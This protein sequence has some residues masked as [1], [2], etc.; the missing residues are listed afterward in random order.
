MQ[1]L[2]VNQNFIPYSI[3]ILLAMLCTHPASAQL[4]FNKV[5]PPLRNFSGIVGGITQDNNG[6]MWIA[7]SGGLYK[8]DGYRFRLYAN[9]P[10][11]SGSLASSRL[12]NVYADSKGMI[13]IATWAE[14]VDRLDPATGIFTHFRHSP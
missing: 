11:N 4:K 1:K 2:S 12:E 8:Y 14:G 9:D 7:T 13:W 3:V 5:L 6:Y 10:A